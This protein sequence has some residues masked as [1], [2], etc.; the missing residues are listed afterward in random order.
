[1]LEAKGYTLSR[2]RGSHHKFAKPGS[3]PVIVPVHHGKVKPFYVQK[4]EKL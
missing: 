4:I 2:I 3:E 1:M